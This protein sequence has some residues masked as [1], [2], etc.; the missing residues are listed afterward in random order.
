MLGAS[1]TGPS[2][3]PPAAKINGSL[4]A[5]KISEHTDNDKI[6]KIERIFRFNC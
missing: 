3:A 5:A 1:A 2:R 6:G 4:H